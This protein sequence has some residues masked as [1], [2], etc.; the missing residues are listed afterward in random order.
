MPRSRASSQLA[1]VLTAGRLGTIAGVAAWV[2]RSL[3]AGRIPQESVQAEEQILYSSMGTDPLAIF[4]TLAPFLWIAK[5]HDLRWTLWEEE[6][7]EEMEVYSPDHRSQLARVVVLALLRSDLQR[8]TV[9]GV[10]RSY[11]ML[12]L[13]GDDDSLL[14]AALNNVVSY[15]ET[16]RH[17]LPATPEAA[18]ELLR[19]RLQDIATTIRR[20][21]EL[22]V[23]HADISGTRVHAVSELALET[24]LSGSVLRSALLWLDAWRTEDQPFEQG[25]T[26]FGVN[27]VVDKEPF[28]EVDGAIDGT[29]LGSSYGH[30]LALAYDGRLA[31]ELSS[32]AIRTLTISTIDHVIEAVRSERATAEQR[33]VLVVGGTVGLNSALWAHPSFIPSLADEKGSHLQIVGYQGRLRVDDGFGIIV[34]RTVIE[35][36]RTHG[37]LLLGSGGVLVREECPVPTRTESGAIACKPLFVWIRAFSKDEALMERMLERRPDWLARM[38]DP[39]DYLQSKA[40]VQVLTRFN[41]DSQNDGEVIVCE[42][43]YPD[44]A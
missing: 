25:K 1:S 2:R 18:I 37:L 33:A 34:V 40:L 14:V 32:R 17:L 28:V 12:H 13:L 44:E 38:P 22:R 11:E 4:N 41:V 35:E 36:L 8:L 9:D 3:E 6:F 39:R 24:L 23:V 29:G 30:S 27:T 19:T 20:E 21:F 5:L 26:Y 42:W 15:Q 43:S 31:S 7:H 10:K 16:W